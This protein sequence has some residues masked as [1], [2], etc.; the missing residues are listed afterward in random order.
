VNKRRV[1]EKEII[2]KKYFLIG[3]Y[4]Y[5]LGDCYET[6][7]GASNALHLEDEMSDGE[8]DIMGILK[9]QNHDLNSVFKNKIAFA[10]IRFE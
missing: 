10:L 7:T 6:F 1:K 3:G 9:I 4:F 5:Y 8:H 2:M